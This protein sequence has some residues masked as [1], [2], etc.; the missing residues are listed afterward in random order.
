V[1]GVDVPQPRTRQASVPEIQPEPEPASPSKPSLAKEWGPL[2]AAIF[3]GV[4]SVVAAAK[5]APET[6]TSAELQKFREEVTETRQQIVAEVKAAKEQMEAQRQERDAD[7]SK[8]VIRDRRDVLM[9]EA[10]SRLNG[11]P[12]VRNW[13]ESD[14]RW[15][16][17]LKPPPLH[18]TD[19]QWPE[20]P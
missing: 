7:K 6:P 17:T 3:A 14:V 12:P 19:Q 10:I 15:V 5:P 16:E 9:A 11:G 13:P 8:N 2:I 4:T 18:R 1:L 20:M